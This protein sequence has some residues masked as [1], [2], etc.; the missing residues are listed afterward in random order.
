MDKN[1]SLKADKTPQTSPEAEAPFTT[2]IQLDGRSPVLRLL[3]TGT[4]RCQTNRGIG[5][6]SSY[7]MSPP[8]ANNRLQPR[9]SGPSQMGYSF[10]KSHAPF[11]FCGGG[12]GGV[13]HGLPVK[14][15]N[16][17]ISGI[18]ASRAVSVGRLQRASI[19]RR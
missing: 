15:K 17:V 8:R 14:S 12:V 11:M 1:A 18:D 4:S 3:E 9:R 19:K 5:C 2:F 6:T 7:E 13:A 16:S 10:V